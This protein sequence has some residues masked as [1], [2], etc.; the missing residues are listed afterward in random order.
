MNKRVPRHANKYFRNK[1]IFFV[2]TIPR[3][4]MLTQYADG[5]RFHHNQPAKHMQFEYSNGEKILRTNIARD[6]V[7]ATQL[8]ILKR[9]CHLTRSRSDPN[10]ILYQNVK[11]TINRERQSRWIYNNS[12]VNCIMLILDFVAYFSIEI[13]Q[14]E[15]AISTAKFQICLLL[16]NTFGWYWNRTDSKFSVQKEFDWKIL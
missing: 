6:C 15:Y 2:D 10:P 11:Q 3:Y 13:L 16:T 14:S 1:Y 7:T 5:I 9:H 12:A 8:W 4:P